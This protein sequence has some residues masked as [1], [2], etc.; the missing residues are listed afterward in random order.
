MPEVHV[1]SLVLL[2][3]ISVCHRVFCTFML[4]FSIEMIPFYRKLG[5]ETQLGV[6]QRIELHCYHALLQIS[7]MA[8]NIPA[9][10]LGHLSHLKPCHQ[11]FCNSR[12]L[13]LNLLC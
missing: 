7:P 5:Q 13:L 12:A 2:L 4:I 10:R 11:G 1:R 9:P 6:L 8:G 3:R